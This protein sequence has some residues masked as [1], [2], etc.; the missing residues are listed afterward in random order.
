MTSTKRTPRKRTSLR[1]G[2]VCSICRH[3]D[4]VLIEQTRIAGGSLDN[5]ARKFAVHR[6]AVWRHCTR[7]I[8]EDLRAQ[9]LA[10]V[11]VKE[12][13]QRASAEGLSVLDY[14]AIVRGVLLQQFQLAASVN[15]KNGTAVLAGRLTEVLRVIAGITGEL[16]RT[17]GVMNVSNTVN[18][19][20]SPIFLDLQTMLVKRL[21]GH[22]DALSAVIEGLREL[23]ARSAP[24]P[25][26]APMIEHQ[27]GAHAP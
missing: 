26:A 7:H 25:M 6:D 12:L 16:M 24:R 4:R 20:N 23:E 19:V 1:K 17:P 14:L 15:D 11:P 8:P 13:A 21:A 2:A 22:P 18:F 10:D 3:P 27:G 5:I 9:Y